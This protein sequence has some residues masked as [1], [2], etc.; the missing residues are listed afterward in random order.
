MLPRIRFLAVTRAGM[1]FDATSAGPPAR[2]PAT[3]PPMIMRRLLLGA[4]LPA[5]LLL[6]R[7]PVGAQTARLTITVL[8]ERTGNPIRD[9]RVEV[10]G[11]R[12]RERTGGNGMVRLNIPTGGRLIEITRLGYAPVRIPIDLQAND[13]VTRIVRMTPE[14]V[15]V[16]GV[17]VRSERRNAHLDRNGFYERERTGLGSFMTSER[18]DQIR[19]SLTIDLFRYM[20]GFAVSYDRRGNPYVA[21]TRGNFGGNCAPLVFMDGMQVSARASEASRWLEIVSPEMIA[22]IEAFPGPAT[23]PPQYNPTGSACGVILVWTKTGPA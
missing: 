3:E 20:R 6:A 13:E 7:A 4:V 18:I 11:L 1:H 8:D 5:A 23:I 10:P 14:A 19:P 9:A 16:S 22:G 21:V 2:P 17:T 15:R 12:D